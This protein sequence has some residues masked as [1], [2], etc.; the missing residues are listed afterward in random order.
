MLRWVMVY[1][2]E[3]PTAP[4]LPKRLWKMIY[5]P[6]I[7]GTGYSGNLFLILDLN[8]QMVKIAFQTGPDWLQGWLTIGYRGTE[9]VHFQTGQSGS[10]MLAT[11]TAHSL[12]KAN[13]GEKPDLFL[14]HFKSV[15]HWVRFYIQNR[16]I[17][18]EVV[19][20]WSFI[21]LNANSRLCWNQGNPF[22]NT[23]YKSSLSQNY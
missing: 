9:L 11:S 2:W 19:I 21:N 23:D 4:G 12:K 3:S 1:S 6:D 7:L 17:L 16:L 20:Y 8:E 13:I 15:K 14:L 10:S 22:S 5:Q 18:F